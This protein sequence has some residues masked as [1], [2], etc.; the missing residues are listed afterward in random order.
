MLIGYSSIPRHVSFF[1]N[2]DAKV[3][4]SSFVLFSQNLQA[5]RYFKKDKWNL[6]SKKTQEFNSWIKNLGSIDIFCFQEQR[7]HAKTL[8]EKGINLPYVHSV[9]TIGTSIYSSFPMKN[10]GFV[11]IGG[12]TKYAAWADIEIGNKVIRVYSVHLSSNMISS[13]T[14]A[15]IT[16]HDLSKSST[17][18]NIASVLSRYGKYSKARNNQL[19]KLMAH[20]ETSP[21]PIIVSGDLNDVPQSYIYKRITKRLNDSFEKSNV[22]IGSTYAGRLPGLRIDYIL[23]DKALKIKNHKVLKETFSDHYPVTSTL[24]F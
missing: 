22:G 4:E 7:Y 17:W 10:K 18:K 1:N 8:I 13:K 6:D 3:D 24:Q 16:D 14:N 23:V 19:D 12:N 20:I 15:I 9:D 5:A 11:A 21:Y 2:S